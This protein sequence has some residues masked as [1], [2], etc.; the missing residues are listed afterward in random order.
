MARR[1]LTFQE[2]I[3][4]LQ[5]IPSDESEEE[6]SN[7]EDDGEEEEDGPIPEAVSAAESDSE[8][9]ATQSSGEESSDSE[10]HGVNRDTL[11]SRAGIKWRR[12]TGQ[13]GAAGRVPALNV[14]A[15]FG[16]ALDQHPLLTAIAV[17]H[18]RV[19]SFL[20]TNPCFVQFNGTQRF[21]RRNLNL[22]STFLLKRSKSLLD[23]NLHEEF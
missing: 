5:D 3:Q 21:K 17:L 13:V 9:S 16:G 10:D 2:M 8:E 4:R 11:T 23:S 18:F 22:I 14:R 15:Y 20:L 12:I 6:I 7:E 19:S 1:K